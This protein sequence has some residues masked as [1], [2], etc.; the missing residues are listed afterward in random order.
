MVF[1]MSIAAISPVLAVTTVNKEI[2]GKGAIAQWH[3]DASHTINAVVSINNNGKDGWVYVSI[4]H[5]R[6]N[7]SVP[8]VS[9]ATG[10]AK[11]QWS[12]DQKARYVTVEATLDFKALSGNARTGM[13]DV[14]IT[15]QA[16]EPTN[17]AQ[18]NNKDTGY[19]MTVDL[20]GSWI[21]SE[22]AFTLDP[23]RPGYHQGD[24]Y[25]SAN[26]AVITHGNAAVSITTP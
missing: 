4:V 20:N 14:L 17:N 22:A 16:I 18:L 13:H 21:Q 3:I 1:V 6:G 19:G 11:I 5:P 8:V 26:F 25:L 24:T 23:I 2:T 7:P 9:E 10:P 12:M 15:W